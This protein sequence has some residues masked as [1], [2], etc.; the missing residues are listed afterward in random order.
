MVEFNGRDCDTA[1]E[2]I[3]RHCFNKELGY[4]DPSLIAEVSGVDGVVRKLDIFK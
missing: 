1:N 2:Y 4:V 3:E